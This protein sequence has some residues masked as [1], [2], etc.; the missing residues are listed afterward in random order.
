VAEPSRIGDLLDQVPG[1]ARHL[2]EARLVRA[3]TTIAGP[4]ATRSHAEAIEDG[5]LR[6]SVDSSG[7]LHRLTLEEAQLLARCRQAA[8]EVTLRAIRF[9]LAPP[10]APAQGAVSGALP[11]GQSEVSS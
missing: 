10:S 1:L 7:W 11:E 2:R 8:P 6:V 5:V 4:A 9:H 3:W